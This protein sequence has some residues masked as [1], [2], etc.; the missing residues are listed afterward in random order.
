MI[1]FFSKDPSKFS[2]YSLS[3][4]DGSIETT[5]FS[6]VSKG[7]DNLI[8]LRLSIPLPPD[9]ELRACTSQVLE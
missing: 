6:V 5:K 8:F 9:L 4:V 2:S 7:I 3:R 1:Y